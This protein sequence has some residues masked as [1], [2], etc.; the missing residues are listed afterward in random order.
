MVSRYGARQ[1][2]RYVVRDALAEWSRREKV[3]LVDA[4][5]WLKTCRPQ[6]ECLFPIDPHWTAKGHFIVAQGLLAESKW[7]GRN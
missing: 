4:T 1:E 5:D 7:S 6:A 2:F 3:E